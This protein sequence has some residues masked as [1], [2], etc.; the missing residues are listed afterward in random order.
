MVWFD[1]LRPLVYTLDA[2]WLWVLIL[3]WCT[4]YWAGRPDRVLLLDDLASLLMICAIF[5]SRKVPA[6]PVKWHVKP[7]SRFYRTGSLT[8]PLFLEEHHGCEYG[9]QYDESCSSFIFE[10]CWLTWPDD[11]LSPMVWFGV[12]LSIPMPWQHSQDR[13][14]KEIFKYG[15][16]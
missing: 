2:D 9:C 7:S 16:F 12:P 1:S 13:S 4:P 3:Y 14:N 11:D 10:V 15:R 5:E 6:A 8:H